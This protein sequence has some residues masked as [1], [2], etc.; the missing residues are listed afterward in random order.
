MLYVAFLRG[1]NVGKRRVPMTRLVSTFRDLGYAD[2]VTFIASGNVIFRSQRR[3]TGLIEVTASAALERELGF[4]VAVMVRTADQVVS[5]A[6]APLFPDEPQ[7]PYNVHVGLMKD[8]AP[9]EE[10]R[11]LEAVRTA[12]D[13][14]RVIGREFYWLC[15]TPMSE[16]IVWTL[17]SAKAVRLPVNTLR[18]MTTLRRLAEKHLELDQ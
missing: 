7:G 15:A 11:K 16:S 3:D 12:T 14:F 18:N 4:E 1:I 5:I 13:Q 8:V 17:P 9:A 6:R 10:A 2:V